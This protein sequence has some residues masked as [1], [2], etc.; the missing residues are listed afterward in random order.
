MIPT[1][2]EEYAGSEV[3]YLRVLDKI[4]KKELVNI[5]SRIK[6]CL[7]LIKGE[8]F[9]VY[10]DPKY[11]KSLFNSLRDDVGMPQLQNLLVFFN[12][13]KSIQKDCLEEGRIIVNSIPVDSG[14]LNTFIANDSGYD[15]LLNKE[16]LNN[17]DSPIHVECQNG[18]KYVKVLDC[19][20][21]EVYRWM[22]EHRHPA[23]KLDENYEKHTKHRRIGRKGVIISALTYTKE[24]V[25]HFLKKAV[26]SS[27]GQKELYF[28][29]NSKGC[30]IIFFNENLSEPT[31]HAFEVDI[32]DSR[33]MEKIHQRGG[34]ELFNRIEETSTL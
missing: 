19:N 34:R 1:P 28:K 14:L 27:S 12:D 9:D 5:I 33:E 6:E 15:S 17:S 30:I 25:E 2:S 20:S 31:F 3:S 29:D 13:F 8:D 26:V 24:E 18:C 23:R 7:R 4:D 32:E 16:A 10:Y 11:L 21:V 22:V